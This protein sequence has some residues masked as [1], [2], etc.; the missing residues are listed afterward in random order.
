MIPSIKVQYSVWIPTNVLRDIIIAAPNIGP[1][2]VN[3]PPKRHM[4]NISSDKTQNSRSGK[5]EPSTTTK[6]TP[7]IPAKKV[8]ITMA[9]S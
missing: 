5:T 9:I 3:H 8:A 6:R 1:A 4:M 2:N 7:A